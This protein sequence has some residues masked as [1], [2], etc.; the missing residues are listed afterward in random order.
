MPLSTQKQN[1]YLTSMRYLLV[2][3]ICCLPALSRAEC[4]V[5]LHGLARSDISLYLL[6]EVLEEQGYKVVRPNYPSTK[7]TI[8][9][10]TAEVLPKTIQAC[11]GDK[12]HFV[13]HSMGGI[14]VRYFLAGDS[15]ENLGRVVMLAPPNQGSEI[16]DEF[17]DWDAFGWFNGPAGKQLGTGPEG[18]PAHLPD[19][20]F[21]LGVIAG[22]RSLSPVFSVI[23]PGDDDGKVSVASTKVK[24]MTDHIVLPVTHT[25][26]MNNPIVVAQVLEFLRNGK[27]DHDL[28]MLDMVL[29]EEPRDE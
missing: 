6:E 3:L 2:L 26:L 28:T 22:S 13:T 18:I 23:L 9:A 24:G 4:V 7:E 29:G 1:G 27:F 17:G 10:L 12:A 20:D 8:A 19:V 16:V 25:F 15:M 5:L 21:E 14:L 11:G